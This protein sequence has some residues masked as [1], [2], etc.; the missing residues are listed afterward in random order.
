MKRYTTIGLFAAVFAVAVGMVGINGLGL[1]PFGNA[2]TSSTNMESY[3]VLG[4][5]T[6]IAKDANGNV[7]S[8]LQTDNIVTQ[9]GE[10]CVVSKVFNNP[11]SGTTDGC[12][13]TTNFRAIAIGTGTAAATDAQTALTTE[14]LRAGATTFTITAAGSGAGA[15][16]VLAKTF[17][18]TTQTIAEAGVFDANVTGG[19]MLAR[20]TFTG[21]PLAASDSLTINW[22]IK[23]GP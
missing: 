23:F 5:I 3:P 7:K 12:T 22:D 2:Q 14:A 10:N 20:Q 21:I 13:S 18:G 15:H 4:H 16:A 8:Y 1:T 9:V 17:T 19:N 6:A 11:K